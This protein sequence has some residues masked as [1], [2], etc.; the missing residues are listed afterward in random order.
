MNYLQKFRKAFVEHDLEYI[1]YILTSKNTYFLK[2]GISRQ[3]PINEII[4]KHDNDFLI[5]L[6]PYLSNFYY[7]SESRFDNQ[8][9]YPLHTAI[10]S[11]NLEA[12]SILFESGFKIKYKNNIRYDV[13]DYAIKSKNKDIIKFII[14]Y[15]SIDL[16]KK[17]NSNETY[18]LKA[19]RYSDIETFN[20]L[21]ELGC[22]P[23]FIRTPTSLNPFLSN[24]SYGG[25]LSQSIENKNSSLFKYL[26][27]N[28]NS[29]NTENVNIEILQKAIYLEKKSIVNWI[30]MQD[31]Y[32]YLLSEPT[33][34]NECSIFEKLLMKEFP[35]KTLKLA[36]SKLTDHF[37]LVSSN[38]D[39]QKEKEKRLNFYVNLSD[40][41]NNNTSYLSKDESAELQSQIIQKF[42]NVFFKYS[43][44]SIFISKV[45]IKESEYA[46]NILSIL[47]EHKN[48]Y[49]LFT[50]TFTTEP[51]NSLNL[52]VDYML[53]KAQEPTK[54]KIEKFLSESLFSMDYNSFIDYNN[55]IQPAFYK[56]TNNWI[57]SKEKEYLM[58]SIQTTPLTNKNIRR[59]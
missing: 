6:K 51:N 41:F 11:N 8:D 57:I 17:S 10:D 45:L 33:Q 32:S 39:K 43:E 20:L 26:A 5:K 36:L 47:K 52:I 15:F 44:T 2:S 13:L 22:D 50:D 48:L 40:C 16:N 59:I 53:N 29:Y 1:E 3:N 7:Y 30:L 58:S 12:I 34:N 9:K 14:N 54:Q 21:I 49:K 18:L 28:I 42:K 56:E 55:K 38:Y 4:K 46:D 24:Q 35:L 37:N 25:V 27:Q 19:C 31:E 23:A